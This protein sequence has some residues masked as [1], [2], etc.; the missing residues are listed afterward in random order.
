MNTNPEFNI[1]SWFLFKGDVE[2]ED[3]ALFLF[4]RII[5]TF[6]LLS[7]ITGLVICIILN[8]TDHNINATI[9]GILISSYIGV[10]TVFGAVFAMWVLKKIFS[11]YKSKMFITMFLCL[12]IFFF[13]FPSLM[14]LL[15]QNDMPL[16]ETMPLFI[17]STIALALSYPTKR[18]WEKWT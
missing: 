9:S 5:H 7:V 13:S 14:P 2:K 3:K 10:I 1:L 15:N 8:I 6:A 17:I 4:I 18:R 16:M 12:K 11:T